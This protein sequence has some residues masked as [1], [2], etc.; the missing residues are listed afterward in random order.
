MTRMQHFEASVKMAQ[1]N[2]F[3]MKFTHGL[4]SL[5]RVRSSGVVEF[6]ILRIPA[7]IITSTLTF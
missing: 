7:L 1:A 5:K 2:G 6:V 3:L 4:Q